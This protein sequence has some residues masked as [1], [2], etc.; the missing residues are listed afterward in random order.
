MLYKRIFTY[1]LF[2]LILLP[3]HGQEQKYTRLKG[4][5]RVYQATNFMLSYFVDGMMEVY[6]PIADQQHPSKEDNKSMPFTERRFLGMRR[7]KAPQANGDDTFI[8]IAMPSLEEK[9]LIQ[10]INSEEYSTRNN[11]DVYRWADKCGKIVQGKEKIN[12]KLEAITTIE[13]DNLVGK[14][15]HEQDMSQL[16]LFGIVARMTQFDESESYLSSLLP[17]IDWTEENSR[18]LG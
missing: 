4:Y 3:L 6:I 1:I 10:S 18:V 2:C 14:D 7:R 15:K 17:K 16:R 12:N 8:R 11:G 5:Y 9:L 13:M